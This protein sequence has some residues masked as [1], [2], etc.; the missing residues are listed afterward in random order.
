MVSISPSYCQHLLM[1]V[2]G[3]STTL[4]LCYILH[5]AIF[6]STLNGIH[7]LMIYKPYVLLKIQNNETIYNFVI[8]CFGGISSALALN[9]K[10]FPFRY[11]YLFINISRVDFNKIHLT[12]C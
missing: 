11:K 6:I 5:E 7:L 8:F 10:R 4:A 12:V 9:N 2:F 1:N 3:S